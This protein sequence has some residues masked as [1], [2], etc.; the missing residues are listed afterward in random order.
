MFALDSRCSKAKHCRNVLGRVL[1][2]QNQ[3]QNPSFRFQ[4]NKYSCLRFSDFFC[5]SHLH[6]FHPTYLS[7]LENLSC[8]LVYYARS[9]LELFL[10]S[11][12]SFFKKSSTI[13]VYQGP[14]IYEISLKCI[15]Y[16]FLWAYLFTW[17][18]KI[19]NYINIFVHLGPINLQIYTKFCE[20]VTNSW[21]RISNAASELLQFHFVK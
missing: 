16:F 14:L 21:M 8:Q 20:P 19:S 18:L 17:N 3:I 15:P 1:G 2:R 12:Y 4:I 6:F 5:Q 7:N 13:S 11:P 9:F 10:S